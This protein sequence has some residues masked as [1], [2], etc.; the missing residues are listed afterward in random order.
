[1]PDKKDYKVRIVIELTAENE[2]TVHSDGEKIGNEHLIVLG[3]LDRV[4]HGIQKIM[5]KETV[6]E[7]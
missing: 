6:Y 1:M 5:D 4:R 2:I 3:I 7:Q